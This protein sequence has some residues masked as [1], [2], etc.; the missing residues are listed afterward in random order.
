MDYLAYK[1]LFYDIGK[2]ALRSPLAGSVW[3]EQDTPLGRRLALR[4][5]KGDVDNGYGIHAATW[6]EAVTYVLSKEHM[7]LFVVAPLPDEHGECYMVCGTAGWRAEAA[8]VVAGPFHDKAEGDEYILNAWQQGYET[9]PAV[10]ASCVGVPGEALASLIRKHSRDYEVVE[11]FVRHNPD[12]DAHPDILSEIADTL[13][14]DL[15]SEYKAR[16]L[17]AAIIRSGYAFGIEGF[18]PAAREIMR[19]VAH[20]S[21]SMSPTT[22]GLFT[23]AALAAWLMTGKA[24][25]DTED[26]L[27]SLAIRA[28][29]HCDQGAAAAML[30]YLENAYE[31][32]RGDVRDVISSIM[33]PL[34]GTVSG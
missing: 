6:D 11:A 34:M 31:M 4:T 7:R 27:V 21:P 10:L 32:A 17:A 8:F 30:Y 33:E 5:T 26:F 1:G 24:D 3:T 18:K 28:M 14:G 25:G 13:L 9:I 23:G 2:E 29:A 12:A 19:Y 22:F 15:S 20:E 16:S